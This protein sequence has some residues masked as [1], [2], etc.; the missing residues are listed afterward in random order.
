MNKQELDEKFMDE[1]IK[2]SEY[3][4]CRRHVG[5]V[6]VKENKIIVSGFNG[7]PRSLQECADMGGCL[8]NKM[9]IASG[10]R[11]E[12]CRAVHAEQ[13]VLINA[14]PC[15]MEGGTLYVN[16]HPCGI[17]ARMICDSPIAKVVY[18]GEY[19][20]K[21]ASEMLRDSDVEIKRLTLNK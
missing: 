1:A 12:I 13:R 17:C 2:V 14:T 19:Q 6:L 10:T 18:L 15:E 21:E 11:Q 16:T 20:D 9:S 3:S 8:R 7:A 4:K 5:A